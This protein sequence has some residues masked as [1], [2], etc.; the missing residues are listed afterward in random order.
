MKRK[1]GLFLTITM[2][3]GMLGGCGKEGSKASVSNAEQLTVYIVQEDALYDTA[4]TEYVQ[5]HTKD[6]IKVE[7]F[8]T[9]EDVNDRL[10]TELMS[11]KGPDVLLFNSLYSDTDPYK[12]ASSGI[13]LDL[14]AQMETLQRADYFEEILD[15]GIVNG[16][17]Y[18]IPLSWNVLQVYATEDK[19]TGNDLYESILQEAEKI[20]DDTSLGLSTYQFFRDDWMNLFMELG[21]SQ[22]LDAK[23][24]TLQD[25]KEAVQKTAEFLQV[26]YGKQ[27]QSNTIGM[28]YNNDFAGALTHMSFMVENFSML[29][30]VRFYETLYLRNTQKEMAMSVFTRQDDDGVTAQVIN[31]GAI[32]ANTQN[33]EAAWEF[34]QSIMDVQASVNFARTQRDQAFYTPVNVKVYEECVRQLTIQ[35]GP[36]GGKLMVGPLSTEQ[37]DMLYAFPDRITEAVIPNTT[38][39]M[40]V[41]ECMDP[42]LQEGVAFDTC[43]DTLLQRTNLY[44]SE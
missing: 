10:Q 16:K 32:N 41:Q 13:L 30:H 7:Y 29:T 2:C 43:Y 27:E 21:G 36:T 3:L 8:E 28:K 23:T 9:Y 34:L 20:A 31:Y 35:K 15:A 17:Q 18:Y 1:L 12:L 5:E 25:Q 42:Y 37:G 24:G 19:V 33:A 39:G 22:V 11:G 26:L 38:F 44:L 6:Q 4:I 40:I 14:D